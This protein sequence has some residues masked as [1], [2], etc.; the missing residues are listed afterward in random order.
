MAHPIFHHDLFKGKVLVITGGG[1]GIGYQLALQ[2]AQ[3]NAKGIAICGRRKEPLEQ[4]KQTIEAQTKCKIFFQ[5]C[6]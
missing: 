3:L 4:A 1:T 6:V 5:T 2:A